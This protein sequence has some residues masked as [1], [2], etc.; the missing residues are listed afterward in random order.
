MRCCQ[1]VEFCVKK[2]KKEIKRFIMIKR[3]ISHGKPFA[4]NSVSRIYGHY[5][6]GGNVPA[7]RL[8]VPMEQRFQGLFVYLLINSSEIRSEVGFIIDVLMS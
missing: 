1:K 5:H 2:G 8:M 3:S 7:S 4:Q 6:V